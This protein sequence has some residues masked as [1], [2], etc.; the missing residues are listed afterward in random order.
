MVTKSLLASDEHNIHMPIGT[1]YYEKSTLNPVSVF[2]TDTWSWMPIL[3]CK[4]LYCVFYMCEMFPSQADF[5][6]RV[7]S[8]WQLSPL[9]VLSVCAMT[10]RQK[11]KCIEH[12]NPSS[13]RWKAEARGVHPHWLP[14]ANNGCNSNSYYVFL[15]LSTNFRGNAVQQTH[16]W[17]HTS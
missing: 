3:Q 15:A 6:C 16:K 17:I 5:L 1:R 4:S 11:L 2:I 14:T 7:L 9:I 10:V 8:R 13:R 12:S